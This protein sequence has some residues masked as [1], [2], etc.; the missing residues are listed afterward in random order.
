MKYYNSLKIYSC[1]TTVLILA[2]IPVAGLC[3]NGYAYLPKLTDS[4]KS[5][6]SNQT[7]SKWHIKIHPSL[8][9]TVGRTNSESVKSTN[10]QWLATLNSNID[11]LGK[12]FDFSSS[13]IAQYGESKKSGE[14]AEKF[15]DV[16]ILSLTPSIP[17]IKRPAIRLFLETTAETSLGKGTLQN[18]PGGFGDPLFLYQTLFLGQKHY[19]YEKDNKIKWD[20][21]YG[22]GY[23]F[24]QTFNNKFQ[25]Q[26]NITGHR[27]GFESGFNGIL[28]FNADYAISKNV[29]FN[30]SSKALAL[31]REGIFNHFDSARKSI[32]LIAG[33]FFTKIGIEYNYH[34][35][36]DSNLSLFP[37]ID[38]SLM[39][40]LR[41]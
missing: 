23:S 6:K 33:I 19:S 39:M 37:M 26:S 15:K 32:L 25:V 22:L 36:N 16:L 12:R 40:T 28:E 41:F 34:Y 35:V 10:L 21:T 5:I 24:Q 3:S 13:V 31:S 11:F 1:L 38:Q 4:I 18:K 29:N 27:Q 17:L 8:G 7:P 14:N 9:L 30:I 2:L 20:L